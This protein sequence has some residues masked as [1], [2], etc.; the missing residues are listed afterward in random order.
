V[1]ACALTIP[2]AGISLSSPHP[3]RAVPFLAIR[4]KTIF[5]ARAARACP[6]RN[7]RI[8]SYAARPGVIGGVAGFSPAGNCCWR[9]FANGALV[10]LLRLRAGS[11]SAGSATNRGA[12]IGGL[13]AR[14]VSSRPRTFLVG[15]IFLLGCRVLRCLLSWSCS[16]PRRACSAAPTAPEGLMTVVTAFPRP[17]RVRPAPGRAAL[18]H[19]LPFLGNPRDPPYCCRWSATIIGR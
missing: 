14:P 7:L 16:Q 18:P 1:L 19:A 12:I 9:S 8:A 15:G 4:P 2:G 3:G 6:R 5:A 17:D 13:R 10:E 11:R